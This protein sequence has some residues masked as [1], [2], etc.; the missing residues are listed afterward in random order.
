MLAQDL[1]H[2]FV[3]APDDL[4]HAQG[5][6]IERLARV[7]LGPRQLD[8]LVPGLVIQSREARRLTQDVRLARLERSHRFAREHHPRAPRGPDHPAREQPAFA[9]T[10]E[11]LSAHVPACAELV[12]RERAGN[13]VDRDLGCCGEVLCQGC[14]FA[15]QRLP[16]DHRVA[17]FVRAVP[18]DAE[19]D[20][21]FGVVL[22]GVDVEGELFGAFEIAQ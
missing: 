18:G 8:D 6:L 13:R 14:Q 3:P 16:H 1:A 17:R 7:R 21:V 22:F 12:G 10:L 15:E 2:G 5:C 4:G 19:D 9:V 20:K 11:C